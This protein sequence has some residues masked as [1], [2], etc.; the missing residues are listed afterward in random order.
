MQTSSWKFPNM[1]DVTRNRVNIAQDAQSVV[2]RVKLLM[3]T[4]PTELYNEL[5]FGV[6]MKRYLWQ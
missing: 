6:G 2:N 1:I 5:D 4:N 3:L